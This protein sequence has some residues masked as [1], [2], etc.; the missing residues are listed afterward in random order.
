MKLDLTHSL[1][2]CFQVSNI[3]KGSV[4]QLPMKTQSPPSPKRSK[5][6][7]QKLTNRAG[8]RTPFQVF[9]VTF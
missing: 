7:E 3:A 5:E 2:K 1:P 8:E 9:Q 4:R 6:R